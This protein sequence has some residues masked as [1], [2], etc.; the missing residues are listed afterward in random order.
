MLHPMA[1]ELLWGQMARISATA[2]ASSSR[3]CARG[4]SG[5][6]SSARS[7]RPRWA[8]SRRARRA[9]SGSRCGDRAGEP[10]IVC[11]HITRIDDDI[12]PDWPRP[13]EGQRGCYAVIIEGEPRFEAVVQLH[14]GGGSPADAGN[15]TA[16]GRLVNAIPAVCAARAGDP[17]PARSPARHGP[18]APPLSDAR[19]FAP[20]TARN[21]API[22]AVLERVLPARGLVLEIASGTGEHAAA[23]AAALPALEFQPSDADP[24]ALASIEAWRRHSG[25]EEP[26]RSA[27]ARRA[28]A[29]V[30][31]AGRRGGR[32]GAVHQHDPHRAVERVSRA[33]RRRRRAARAG[34]TARALRAVSRARRPHRAEQRE[35]RREPARARPALGRSR[36]RTRSPPR[37][38]RADSRSQRW[39]RCRPTIARSCSSGADEGLAETWVQNRSCTVP[40][41]TCASKS[42]S[43]WPR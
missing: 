3:R 15:A 35:L 31:A 28:R 17:R 11:E 34:R 8:C 9:R 10:V 1:L 37:R 29:A 27:A 19:R 41:S 23:F 30:A 39:S 12:A 5:A 7:T 18:R 13:P 43:R 38:P 24:D 42:P 32:R 22:L 4:S 2:S 26:A 20:A 36:S 14:G 6:R 33:A 25:A 16:A 21:R 40:P